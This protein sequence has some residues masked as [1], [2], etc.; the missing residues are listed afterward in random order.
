MII[1]HVIPVDENV[2]AKDR[3]DTAGRLPSRASR[4]PSDAMLRLEEV[5]KQCWGTTEGLQA[6]CFSRMG[7]R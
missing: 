4:I 3:K 6:W 7:G 2:P 5:S 1:L